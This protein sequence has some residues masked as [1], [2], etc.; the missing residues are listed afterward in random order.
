MHSSTLLHSLTCALALALVP[1]FAVFADALPPLSGLAP[2]EGQ[3]YIAVVDT[4]SIPGSEQEARVL[5]LDLSNR[6]VPV[7]LP[8]TCD[9][10][11]LAGELPND[12]EAITALPNAPHQFLCVESSYSGDQFGR[13]I[14]L[15]LRKSE[16]K[17]TATAVHVQ[18]FPK[19]IPGTDVELDNIEGCVAFTTDKGIGLLLGKRGKNDKD[20][21]LLLGTYNPA[22]SNFTPADVQPFAT[23]FRDLPNVKDDRRYCS[24]L[25]LVGKILYAGSCSDPGDDGPFISQIYRIGQIQTTGAGVLSVDA[26]GE[27]VHTVPGEKI[28]AILPRDTSPAFI[29][30][31]DNENAGGGFLLLP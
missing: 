28:E 8:L 3:Q 13:I 31:T 23:R 4:K 24:D 20:A 2:L 5:A 1:A 27:A 7:V 25:A 14:R 29:A 12:L 10:S 16:T 15:E 9:W 21:Y 26:T 22:A 11:L 19:Q 30:A 17:W 6:N 18:H